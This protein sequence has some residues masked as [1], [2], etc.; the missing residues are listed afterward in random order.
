[1]KQPN[2]RSSRISQ[3]GIYALSIRFIVVR[4]RTPEAGRLY[5]KLHKLK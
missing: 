3:L 2:I 4:P 5:Y 1:M